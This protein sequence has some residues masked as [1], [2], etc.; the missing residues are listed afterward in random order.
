MSTHIWRS[1][2]D[3]AR[4]ASTLLTSLTEA[5]AQAVRAVLTGL[6][7]AHA[8]LSAM[9]RAVAGLPEVE[10]A[11]WQP[12]VKVLA[13]R[14]YTLAT[15]IYANADEVGAAP[16]LVLG[17]LALTGVAC[18]WALVTYEYVRDLAAQTQLAA[19]ELDARIE[20]MRTNRQLPATTL[21]PPGGGP[22][23]K[24]LLLAGAALAALGATWF[25]LRRA[26]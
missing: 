21:G 18:A 2:L 1:L 7:D 16:L 8:T 22:S 24:T 6:T 15:P 26:A 4:S 14:Y 19:A 23:A 17:G 20:A 5:Q 10:R 12:V 13:Q 3:R 9:E 11:G 25:T